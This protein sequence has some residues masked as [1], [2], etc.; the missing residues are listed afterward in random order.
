MSIFYYCQSGN[1]VV[2]SFCVNFVVFSH[3]S[4]V[5]GLVMCSFWYFL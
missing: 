5:Y 1:F 3:F 2:L 4:T